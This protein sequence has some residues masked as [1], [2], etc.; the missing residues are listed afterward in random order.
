MLRKVPHVGE[1]VRIVYLAAE[2]RGAIERVSE[3][4]RELEVLSED[5]HILIFRLNQ[6]TA[7]F[8]AIG[9]HLGARLSFETADIV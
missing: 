8:V 1:S 4:M 7:R 3:D 2:R 9:D 5:G 6:A